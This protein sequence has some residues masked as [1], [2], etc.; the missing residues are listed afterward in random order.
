LFSVCTVTDLSAAEK[1]SGVKRRM[2]VRPLPGQVFSHFGELWLAWIHGGGVTSGMS[3][4]IQVAVGQ[5]E[6][7]AAASRKAV[8]WDL[9]L[10]SLLTHS[11]HLV[12]VF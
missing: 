7:A 1:D 12:T 9:R 6:L 3:Y 10:A 2:L 4:V 11:F 5:S 8:W